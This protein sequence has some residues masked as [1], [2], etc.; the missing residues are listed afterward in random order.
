MLDSKQTSGEVGVVTQQLPIKEISGGR[1][2]KNN[3][4]AE[5]GMALLK[6]DKNI[7]NQFLEMMQLKLVQSK[8]YVQN[9]YF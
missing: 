3:T 5:K 6:E 7:I 9:N 1:T 2:S 8:S 4:D